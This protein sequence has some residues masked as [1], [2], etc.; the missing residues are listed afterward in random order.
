MGPLPCIQQ[1]PP[2][3]GPLA[4]SP[5][6]WRAGG[7]GHICFT[8]HADTA[9]LLGK[10]QGSQMP[11]EEEDG[12]EGA[13]AGGSPQ[14]LPGAFSFAQ[15]YHLAL[16]LSLLISK[17]QKTNQGQ[18]KPQPQALP[19]GNTAGEL[20]NTLDFLLRTHTHRTRCREG[21]RGDGEAAPVA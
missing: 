5:G 12:E 20:N 8:G 6:G 18:V 15:G 7:R 10:S 17:A 19:A 16:M 13:A 4:A 1:P 14:H 11:R 21:Q 3:W 2:D 9:G